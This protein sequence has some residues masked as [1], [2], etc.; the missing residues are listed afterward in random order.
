MP[1]FSAA[2]LEKLELDYQSIMGT[3]REIQMRI[4]GQSDLLKEKQRLLEEMESKRK[5]IDGYQSDMKRL[6]AVSEQLHM[7][8]GSLE[9]T[10]EQLR[11]DFVSSVND[12]MQSIWPELYPYK[13]FTSIRLGI[14]DSDYVLQLQDA[15]GWTA[16][17]GIVSGGERSIA[18]L[19]LRIALS[20]VLAPSIDML[21]LDE[22]TANL[23]SKT[24]EVLANVLRD[25]ITNF[26]DQVFLITHDT[27]LENA[28]SGY[29]Y[30]M[31][32]E[33]TKNDSTK[34]TLVSGS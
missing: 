1:S 14:E 29:L 18:C 3:E 11:K 2:V 28:V 15:T 17:D 24:V 25:N 19:A 30:R 22:P 5:I 34:V 4:A 33:K 8:E 27:A 26:V 20:L 16:A 23:D 21:V 6:E 10:Q 12:A 31:E 7:L 32:R 9:L 13:D